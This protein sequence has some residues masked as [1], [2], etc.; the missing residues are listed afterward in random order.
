MSTS[1]S[2]K[3]A[4]AANSGRPS[5]I[6]KPR[7]HVSEDDD[8]ND[9]IVSEQTQEQSQRTPS[10]IVDEPMV[11]L[12]EVIYLFLFICMSTIVLLLGINNAVG[13]Y[14]TKVSHLFNYCHLTYLSYIDFAVRV[15]CIVLII[16]LSLHRS[17]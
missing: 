7:R 9:S 8:S 2:H 4:G 1:T 12:P 17:C 16:L 15:R 6:R 10:P 5:K 11:K 14:I 3:R 13:N